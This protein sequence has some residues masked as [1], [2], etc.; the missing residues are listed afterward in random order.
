[1]ISIAVSTPTK[2]FTSP[3]VGRL[4]LRADA[5]CGLLKWDQTP[6]TR[7]TS[8]RARPNVEPISIL[9]FDTI[10]LIL[11]LVR[12]PPSAHD[13]GAVFLPFFW[14]MKFLLAYT[15][16][17]TR[18]GTSPSIVVRYPDYAWISLHLRYFS[19]RTTWPEK[20]EQVNG[21]KIRRE[22]GRFQQ[23][24]P[25]QDARFTKEIQE[26][27]EMRASIALRTTTRGAPAIWTIVWMLDKSIT[28]MKLDHVFS[29]ITSKTGACMTPLTGLLTL[30]RT[31]D[32]T[33]GGWN[34]KQ[35]GWEGVLREF[36]G[37]L[38]TLEDELRIPVGCRTVED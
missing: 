7:L 5:V 2:R 11:S 24:G 18:L 23:L 25:A 12:S 35:P 34:G 9:P 19:T 37:V 33:L 13:D 17:W 20:T 38:Q 14:V 1:M 15:S 31:I 22:R 26:I 16:K 27:Q 28:P 29:D 30:I 4:G 6:N 32:F 10:S 21:M 8:D 3:S 36:E